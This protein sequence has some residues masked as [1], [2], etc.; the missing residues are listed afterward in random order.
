MIDI[1]IPGFKH[2]KIHHL[3][4]DYNGTLAID[5]LLLDGVAR[6]LRTFSQKIQV[7]IITADTF[8]LVKAQIEDLP[9]KVTIL[10]SEGLIEAKRDYVF[11][12]GLESVVAIGNGRND[13]AMLKDAALGIAVVQRE[14]AAVET[15]LSADLVVSH[16]LDALD[17]LNQPNRLVASL[18]A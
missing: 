15:L 13:S 4:L 18:R 11:K 16:I 10:P 6:R 3:V 9:V 7:H 12:L 17:F 14:G 1:D 2:L 5:G 8:G